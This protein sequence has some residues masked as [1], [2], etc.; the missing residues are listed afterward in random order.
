MGKNRLNLLKIQDCAN[1][2]CFSKLSQGI[3]TRHPA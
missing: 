2:H 3:G 1:C